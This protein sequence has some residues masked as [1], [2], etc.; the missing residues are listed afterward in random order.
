MLTCSSG[1]ERSISIPSRVNS[2]E[3]FP[4]AELYW[5]LGGDQFAQLPRWRSVGE[6]VEQVCFLVLERPGYP[7]A[8]PDLAGLRFERV[9]A[10]LMEESS[11]EVRQ[12]IQAGNPLNGLVP[13]PVEAFIREHKLY[14]SDDPQANA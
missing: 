10:P 7:V 2:R 4:A 1:R 12:R 11:T 5:I 6:L 13:E 14:R 3:R 8:A 9:P